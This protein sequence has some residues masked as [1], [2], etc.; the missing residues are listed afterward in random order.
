MKEEHFRA[1]SAVF[2]VI[3]RTADNRKQVLLHRRANTGY[4]D[5]MLDFAGSG[6]VDENESAT[7]AVVRECMEEL[8]IIVH[9]EDVSFAHLSH[10][11]NQNSQY[12]Y[13]DIYF[14]VRAYEGTPYIAEPDK[15][16]QL[17]WFDVEALPADVIEIRKMALGQLLRSIYYSEVSA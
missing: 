9:P 14:F 16:T 11:L 4:M 6:H 13:Y 10:R 8:G 5:G 7:Q 1:L 2:P 15:S 12:T 17:E 3:L